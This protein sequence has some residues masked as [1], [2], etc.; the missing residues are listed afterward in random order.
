[1]DQDFGAAMRV[2]STAERGSR[3]EIACSNISEDA[4]G[5]GI[6]VEP[7]HSSNPVVRVVCRVSLVDVLGPPGLILPFVALPR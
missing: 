6:E 2:A 4:L 7:W 1:M 5:I 3:V